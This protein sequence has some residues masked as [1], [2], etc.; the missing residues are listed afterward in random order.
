[1][2]HVHTSVCATRNAHKH[3][4]KSVRNIELHQTFLVN[5]LHFCGRIII[6]TFVHHSI[7]PSS[8]HT[9][10]STRSKEQDAASVHQADSLAL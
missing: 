8:I 10:I 4:T 2:Q 3:S 5:G 7:G 9:C 6:V 1:M